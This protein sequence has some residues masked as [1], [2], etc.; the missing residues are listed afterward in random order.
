MA[1]AVFGPRILAS[2]VCMVTVTSLDPDLQQDT[3]R[4][5]VVPRDLDGGVVPGEV[6]ADGVTEGT[7]D[8]DHDGRELATGGE[9]PVEQVAGDGGGVGA[10]H[11]DVALGG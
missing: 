9:Q 6:P 4:R 7:V 11:H 3:G 5:A 8:A 10:D 1:V 2:G